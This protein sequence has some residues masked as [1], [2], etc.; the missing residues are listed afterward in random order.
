M[1]IKSSVESNIETNYH[2]WKNFNIQNMGGRTYLQTSFGKISLLAYGNPSHPLVIC[3]H[4]SPSSAE[5]RY[6]NFLLS[7]LV[8][9]NFY[10]VA[11]DMPGCGKSTGKQLKCRCEYALKQGQAGDFVNEIRKKL[12]AKKYS[13]VGYDWGAGIGLAMSTSKKFNGPIEQVVSF[14]PPAMT[15]HLGNKRN[16]QGIN[17]KVMVIFSKEI[18]FIHGI[19]GNQQP[20]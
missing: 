2:A 12:G 7:C 3:L 9:H 17:S 5:Y 19:S 1:E 6:G 13:I 10:A 20:I 16:V 4:G 15:D 11:I 8:Y 18:I 14:H